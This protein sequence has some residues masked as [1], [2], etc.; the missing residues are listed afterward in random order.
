MER[1]GLVKFDSTLFS[2]QEID[3]LNYH[4]NKKGFTNGLDIRNKYLHGSNSGSE[5]GHKNEYY[6]LLRL[7]ILVLLKI[8]DD[9][10]LKIAMNRS[11]YFYYFLCLLI[12]R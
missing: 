1:D 5:K 4:L 2:K 12:F 3:Y 8:V 9:L 10:A 6:I 11:C 7:I